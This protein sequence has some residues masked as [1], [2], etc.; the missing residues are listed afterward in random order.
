MK[1]K[2]YQSPRMK[3]VQVQQ[4]QIICASTRS[5]YEEDLDSDSFEEQ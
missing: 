2:S 1:M 3:V 4:I 5:M